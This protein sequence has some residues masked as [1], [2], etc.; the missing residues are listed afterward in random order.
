MVKTRRMIQESDSYSKISE[1]VIKNDKKKSTAKVQ[2]NKNKIIKQSASIDEL[3]KLCR[4]VTVLIT[5]CDSFGPLT[6]KF[7]SKFLD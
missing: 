6:R 2:S 5:K 7:E 1:N 3:L 4:P